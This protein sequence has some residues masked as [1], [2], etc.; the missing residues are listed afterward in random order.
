MG[1]ICRKLRSLFRRRR[2]PPEDN[3]VNA[4][5]NHP[6]HE[7]GDNEVSAEE[8]DHLNEDVPTL[9]DYFG[10]EEEGSDDEWETIGEGQDNAS[11]QDNASMY[12]PSSTEVS[13]VLVQLANLKRL[14]K[15]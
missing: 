7:V 1:N 10:N 14:F 15:C 12:R 8:N 3:L 4:D 11:I 2:G 6:V 5:A 9:Q 13:Q